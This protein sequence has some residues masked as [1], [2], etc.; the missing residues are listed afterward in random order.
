MLGKG[1][2]GYNLEKIKPNWTYWNSGHCNLLD[3]K[4]THAKIQ[5]FMPDVIINAAGLVG[6]IKFNSENQLHMLHVNTVMAMNVFMAMKSIRIH[7]KNSRVI[8]LLSTCCYPAQLPDKCYPLKEE[9]M[10]LGEPEPTNKGYTL[11]KRFIK[12][13]IDYNR[14]LGYRDVYLIPC[15]LY[16]DGDNYNTYS[17]HLIPSLIRKIHYAKE[18]NLK[19]ITCWGD[20]TVMRQCMH[21]SDL[22]QAITDWVKYDIN[23]C[24]NVATEENYTIKRIVDIALEACDAQ[25]LEVKWDTTKPNGIYRKDV[26]IEKLKKQIN[27][28]PKTLLTGLRETYNDYIRNNNRRL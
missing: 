1:L 22:A 9:M 3:Y 16:G 17:S 27:W 11:H 18:N 15:N 4:E 20:G 10:M 5:S 12:T 21:A 8:H 19:S 13:T 26:S 23:E 6:G 25:D 14:E 2:V 28:S 7:N 24:V